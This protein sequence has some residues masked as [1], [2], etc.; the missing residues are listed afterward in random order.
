MSRKRDGG[1]EGGGRW[2]G[3]SW[4][5]EWVPYAE[6]GRQQKMEEARGGIFGT[7]SPTSTSKEATI[8]ELYAKR[9]ADREIQREH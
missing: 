1:E 3:M 7:R 8:C 9:D 2:R 5:N 6:E 4:R